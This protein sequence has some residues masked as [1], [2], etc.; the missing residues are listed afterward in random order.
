MRRFGVYGSGLVFVIWV[1][2]WIHL[3]GG[4]GVFANWS[5]Q[6]T[7]DFTKKAGFEVQNILVEGRVHTDVDVLKAIINV[8][9]G[10]PIFSLS[11]QEAREMIEKLSWVKSARIERRLPDTIF[12]NL[13]ERTPL[14]LWQN[15]N[16]LALIDEEGVVLTRRNLKRFEDLIIIVGKGAP[17]EAFGFLSTLE[18]EPTIEERVQSAVLVSGRRWD[19]VTQNNVTIQL[20]QQDAGFALR[21]LAVLQDQDDIFSKPLK[22]IDIRNSEKIVVQTHRG[23]TQEFS[24]DY[25]TTGL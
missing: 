18:A 13:E 21:R 11:P 14:A 22:S 19:L 10:D 9:K 17:K 1:T 7:L 15:N 4:F 12:I 8:Q 23:L 2:A 16:K 6:K 24:A 20:P 25:Q 3:S 5:N